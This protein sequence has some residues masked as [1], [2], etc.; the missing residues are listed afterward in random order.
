MLIFA[1]CNWDWTSFGYLSKK[2]CSLSI[3]LI[4][5]VVSMNNARE[6]EI[7]LSIKKKQIGDD[8]GEDKKKQERMG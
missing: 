4:N 1:K 8:Y 6:K 3:N 5:A 2:K 7:I